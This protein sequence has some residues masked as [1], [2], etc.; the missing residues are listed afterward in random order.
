MKKGITILKLF[1]LFVFNASVFFIHNP[2]ILTVFFTLIIILLLP[3]KYLVV[4]RLKAIIPIGIM[5]LI[6]QLIFYSSVPINQRLLFG[7]LSAMKILLVSLSVL[8][9]LSSTSLIELVRV[10]DFLPKDWLLLFMITCY[11][12]PCLL[13]ESEKIRIVQKSRNAQMQNWN[14][15][16]NLGSL[17]I[18]LL[19]RV[20]QRAEIL[21]LAI[22]SRGYGIE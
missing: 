1:S 9:F 19:H 20:F 13:N 5:I 17:I 21:S 6:S 8:L 22:V 2:F 18:P 15:I 11:L 3:T 7:Y 14:F 4:K 10:F 12:I 16:A